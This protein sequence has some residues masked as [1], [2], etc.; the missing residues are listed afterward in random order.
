[1]KRNG[2]IALF[3]LFSFAVAV[4]GLQQDASARLLGTVLA[5][6]NL[7][8]GAANSTL[9]EIDPHT[10]A[11]VQTIGLV[12]YAVNGLE[13]NERDG[14]LYGT[15]A[16]WD[17]TFPSGLI[18]ID[19]ATGAGT[20]IGTGAG[21]QVNNPTRGTSTYMYAWTEDGD[22]LVRI[23]T[24]T[25]VATVAGDNGLGDWTG[26]LGLARDDAGTLFLVNFNGNV[27]T[28][29]TTGLVTLIGP[30]GQRAH[31]GDFDQ[32]TGLYFGLGGAYPPNTGPTR[33]LVV[34]EVTTTNIGVHS[35]IPTV[36]NLMTLSFV[37]E[38][39]PI[40]AISGR[41]LG[42]ILD[43][44]GNNSTLVEVDPVT[45]ATTPIGLVGYEVNGLE[46]NPIDGKLYG[47]TSFNDPT[48]P[49]GLIQ[50]NMTTGAGT[51]IGSGTGMLIN[52]PT[53]NSAGQM[54]AWT[55]DS[56]D[57]V[58]VN[59]ANGTA[60]VV[61]N[62]GVVTESQGLAFDGQNNLFLVNGD[63][64]GGF[65]NVY[66]INPSTGVGIQ[67][68]NLHI[69]AHHGDFDPVTG[70]YFGLDQTFDI[71]IARKLVIAKVTSSSSRVLTRINTTGALHT[72]TFV[73]I[74]APPSTKGAYRLLGTTIDTVAHNS[75]LV[76]LDPQ[77]GALVR[78]IGTV[79]Y[80]VNGL[81]YDPK[82]N[83][84]Y[85]T[86]S[87]NDPAFPNGLIRIDP[88]TGAGTP[89]GSGAGM[90]I[91]LPT[92]SSTGQ[93]YAW[94]EDSDDLVTVNT[95]TG[96]ATVVGDSGVSTWEHGLAFDM[97]NN[98][99]LVNGRD[100]NVYLI[101]PATGT[102]TTVESV[103]Q[104]MH[105]GDFDPGTGLYFGIDTIP[106]YD[107]T[108]GNSARNL[109]VAQIAPTGAQARIVRPTVD[110]LMTL[111]F[112]KKMFPWAMFVPKKKK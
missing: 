56:D 6:S 91:N 89:I 29:S 31:H 94:T 99:F 80:Q 14:L 49:D 77:T 30:L 32:A 100:L 25:G 8:P 38:R 93:M 19:M 79:G 46:Y 101:S 44:A 34:A 107:E 98:L 11:L 12:G 41:L 39:P 5:G 55:E 22:D 84:L 18:R 33:S 108:Y 9:V 28:V 20:P 13:F 104:M 7:D 67:V 3:F 51:P 92:V 43:Q 4:L 97:Q 24:T 82:A 59:T 37:P 57:L 40:T 90:L 58:T 36:D 47:T 106:S 10:G 66:T 88:S 53:V 78:T 50:I 21:M 72:L 112:Y 110:N 62:S 73:P 26:T 42:T 76:E 15:T 52:N 35:S 95:A 61:G 45:G 23:D 2:S 109:V 27:Y 69:L 85:G 64:G 16:N 81:E 83:L 63:A 96:T 86:T 54:Y 48:F 70:L 65:G 75:T 74:A 103:G 68:G 71:T 17:P 102:A 1:M 105:H 60:T 111:A 87:F